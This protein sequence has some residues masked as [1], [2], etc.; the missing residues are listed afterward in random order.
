MSMMMGLIGVDGG[1]GIVSPTYATLDGT[2]TNTTLSG[3]NLIASHS[4]SSGGGART[5]SGLYYFEVTL[6]ALNAI[7]S[8]I[9][10]LKSAGAYN[11]GLADNT[12][13]YVGNG[14]GTSFG[15]IFANTGSTGFALGSLS[16]SPTIGVAVDFT[17]IKIWFRI[18]PSG[19]W[20]GGGTADPAT[21]TGRADISGAVGGGASA[22]PVVNFAG[23]SSEAVTFNFGASAFVG[24]VPS[25]F[26]SGW[27]PYG[28]AGLTTFKFP[29]LH[30]LQSANNK[31]AWNLSTPDWQN[32]IRAGQSLIPDMPLLD[33]VAAERAVN[34]FDRLRLPDV[35]GKPLLK[36]AAGDW[37]RDIVRAWLRR[38]GGAHGP[39]AVFAGY[40]KSSKTSYGAALM[41]TSLLI[42]ERPKAEFL[43]IAP[44]QPIAEIA[45]N[46][47]EGMIAADQRLRRRDMMQVQTHLKKVTWLETGATLQVKS[48]DPN[49]LTGVKPAGA[50]MDELHVVSTNANTDRVI[51]QLRGDLISQPEGF[52]TFITTQSERPPA[53][54]FRPSSI[55]PAR[56]ANSDADDAT[57]H[58]RTGSPSC[59]R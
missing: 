53:G 19:N 35:T 20:N 40:E 59:D 24:T 9:A 13:L 11:S 36:D 47:V 5:N 58:I 31:M 32:R 28:L 8:G 52:L 57:D 26:T 21:N 48:F 1:G 23:N 15:A 49:V 44:T 34:V 50:L 54:V 33:K 2:P 22:G 25:G 27:P 51:G 16:G 7:T 3:G 14:G 55:R 10:L 38:R 56:S 29:P 30:F 4:N 18:A 41:L 12:V 43:L 6:T 39:R 17:H 37:F 45:F 46:Q 42:N